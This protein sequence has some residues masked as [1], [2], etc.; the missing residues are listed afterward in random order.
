MRSAHI[1]TGSVLLTKIS[2]KL[3]TGPMLKQGLLKSVQSAANAD[4]KLSGRVYL[5]LGK[6][7]TRCPDLFSSDVYLLSLLLSMLEQV[8]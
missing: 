2:K 4:L 3:T 7:S 8:L 6:L 5:G 1:R